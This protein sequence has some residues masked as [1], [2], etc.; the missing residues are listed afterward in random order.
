M[1]T[2]ELQENQLSRSAKHL[3]AAKHVEQQQYWMAQLNGEWITT[4]IPADY[5][6]AGTGDNGYVQRS[7]LLKQSLAERIMRTAKGSD[8]NVYSVLLAG[9][10]ALLR[11]YLSQD[12][13][14][15][16]TPILD[17]PGHEGGEGFANHTLPLRASLSGGQSFRQLLVQ[18]KH[19]AGNA[20]KHQNYPADL[21][22]DA[23]PGS[24]AEA[25]PEGGL[26]DTMLVFE[27]LQ[28]LSF[29]LGAAPKLVLSFKCQADNIMLS[30]YYRA[31]LYHPGKIDRLNVHYQGLLLNSLEAPDDSISRHRLEEGA[32]PERAPVPEVTRYR[33]VTEAFARQ[34]AACPD[35]TALVLE[36][37]SVTYADLEARAAQMAAALVAAGAGKGRLVGI[38]LDRSVEMIVAIL[39][40][41]K[42]G[43]CYLPLDV[44]HPRERRDYMLSDSGCRLVITTGPH[45]EKLPAGVNVLDVSEPPAVDVPA[46]PAPEIHPADPLYV[47]YTSG[48]TGK[49]KGVVIEHRNLLA[50]FFPEKPLF[51]FGPGDTWTM[52]HSYCFDFSVWEMFGALLFGGRLVLMTELQLRDPAFL[53]QL[54]E[55]EQVSVLSLTPSAFYNLAA[56]AQ[57]R[58]PALP[59]LR[60]VVFGGEALSPQKLEKWAA[61]YPAARLINMY[62]ITEITIHA[63]FKEITA[64]EIAGN[65]SNIGLPLPHLDL[66]LLNADGDALPP[67]FPGEI[68]VTGNGVSRGYLNKP[69]LSH[70]RFAPRHGQPAYLS[71]DLAYREVTS[72]E[73]IYIGRRDNQVQLRGYRIELGEIEGALL[74]YPGI[75]TALVLLRGESEKH[76]CAYYVSEERMDPQALRA[77]L[78][79][80]LPPYMV[81][82]FFIF[83]EKL[84]LNH[85]G[86]IDLDR[87]PGQEA[88]PGSPGSYAYSPAQARMAGLWQQ[89]L[90]AG[91]ISPHESYFSVGGDSIKAISLL[92]RVNEAYQAQLQLKD[93]YQYDTIEKLTWLV[94]TQQRPAR[95]KERQAVE[96]RLHTLKQQVLGQD[97][98]AADIDDVYPMADIQKGMVFYAAADTDSPLY[99]D[100]MVHKL[101]YEDFDFALFRKAVDLL[102]GKHPV[103]RTAF[104]LYDY[105]EPVQIVYRTCAA[106]VAFT[107]L[108]GLPDD[109]QK[110]VIREAARQDRRQPFRLEKAPLW[111]IRIFALDK[112]TVVI[113]WVCHHAIIDGWSDAAFKTEL[114]N[115][116]V[117]LKRGND[118]R[119]PP[120]PHTYRD[121]VVNEL[122]SHG[123]EAVRAFW[124]QELGDYQRLAVANQTSHGNV[125]VPG[126]RRVVFPAGLFARLRGVSAAQGVS[127]KNLLFTACLITL[128]T[129]ARG[130]RFVVGLATHNRPVQEDADQ[131]LGC[132]LNI[133]PF[134]AQLDAGTSW[135]ELARQV[136]HKTLALKSYDQLSLV[137]IVKA[138]GEPTG[139]RN[140]FFDTLFNFVDFHVYDGMGDNL[141]AATELEG[142]TG[143]TNTNTLLD[144]NVSNTGAVF[145]LVIN[146]AANLVDGALVE[147]LACCFAHVLDRLAAGKSYR[148]KTG[149]SQPPALELARR[150]SWPGGAPCLGGAPARLT[151]GAGQTARVR[152]LATNL[153]TPMAFFLLTSYGVLL[154]KYTLCDDLLIGLSVDGERE[155]L[156]NALLGSLGHLLPV[157]LR[158]D[159]SQPLPEICRRN[160]GGFPVPYAGPGLPTDQLLDLLLEQSIPVDA[161]RPE[162]VLMLHTGGSPVPAAPGPERGYTLALHV[163]EAGDCLTLWFSGSPAVGAE[164]LHAMTT[165]LGDV[166]EQVTAGQ[167]VLPGRIVLSGYPVKESY[168][169]ADFTGS[170]DF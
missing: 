28:N 130:G 100:Q 111:R 125:L 91:G 32:T 42:A 101:T 149:E 113:L 151:L 114:N 64:R 120:L 95:E 104:N 141:A 76:L 24:A 117:N 81:P 121:Y 122:I 17:K 33:S 155:P 86:K 102:A 139:G 156:A 136:E 22:K 68:C 106:D 53:L 158:L 9:F 73:F 85:N 3:V 63:T 2:M 88:D 126:S 131:M 93:I 7:F 140:P 30:I 66:H 103:L 19:T 48:T 46:A 77:S 51:D 166:I 89:H 36:G 164:T 12:Q 157:R 45:R 87:L 61:C 75:A 8:F 31:G 168:Q 10:F 150:L 84:P 124:R 1:K 96:R 167:D 115:V 165:H 148:L 59:A 143:Y 119:L 129:I 52:F 152:Q 99:H 80:V 90:G 94:E 5:A 79:R 112:D 142:V 58:W 154:H 6:P 82:S 37:Q 23:L 29:A 132:F 146:Y 144:F 57:R 170:F 34:A 67:G 16:G 50:L 25:G 4:T 27:N 40:V 43:A 69:D 49:P 55:R 39:A 107:D 138:V 92:C 134:K 169:A 20:F 123:D 97:P 133:V 60:Y 147:R 116:Y 70:R 14:Q 47:I 65:Q 72:K 74:K 109:Q 161:P 128:N 35:N 15:V 153:G 44:T 135:L 105:D 11:K 118:L 78:A 62:G 163:L 110:A 127:P 56:E 71:G 108:S 83:L 98:G 145:E 41:G 159:A 18:V 13:L 38:L 26:F 54:L 162:V 137:E 21:L 160:A